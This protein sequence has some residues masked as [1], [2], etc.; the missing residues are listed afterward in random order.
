MK[1]IVDA[2]FGRLARWLRLSG[3]DAIYAGKTMSDEEILSAAK[4]SD[5]VIITRD[6]RIYHK[7]VKEDADVVFIKTMDFLGQLKQLEQEYKI[8]FK[9][10]PTAS[11]CPACNGEVEMIGKE[12]VEAKVSENILSQHDTFWMCRACGKIYWY[13]GHWKNIASTVKKIRER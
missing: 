3:Y 4:N 9:D 1:F 8:E 13:G 10:T 11:R 12:D 2:M 7:A 6:R 5:R